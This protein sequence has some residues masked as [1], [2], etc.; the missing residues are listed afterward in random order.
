MRYRYSDLSRGIEVMNLA[1]VERALS[2]HPRPPELGQLAEQPS[3]GSILKGVRNS[4][5]DQ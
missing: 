2:I 4:F 5:F 3:L 1:V